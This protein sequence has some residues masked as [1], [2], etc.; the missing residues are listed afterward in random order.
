M[1]DTRRLIPS[2]SLRLD[3]RGFLRGFTAG[4]AGMALGS[5]HV[6]GET[7]AAPVAVPDATVN[8]VAGT[9]RRDMVYQAL[10][11]FAKEVKEGIKGKQVIVKPNM[12]VVNVPLCATHADALRGVLDFLKPLTKQTVL[13]AE[14]TLSKEGSF[15]GFENYGYMPLEK[16]YNARLV[17]LNKQPP[18]MFW[19]LDKNHHPLGIR[20]IS[21]FLDPKNYFISVSR[22]KT[23]DTVVATLTGK[24]MFMSAPLNDYTKSDKSLMHQGIKEINWNLFQVAGSVHPQLAVLDGL[25][26]MQGNGPISGVAAPH[27]VALAGTDYVAVDH[28]GA[29]LMGVDFNDIGYLTYCAS[30][31]YGQ[32][33]R[34]K[35]QVTGEDPARHVMKYRMHEK[36]EEELTWKS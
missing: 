17:D 5:F 25:E 35:I 11:P 7:P 21:T 29:E 30:A 6:Y 27:G 13:I 4:A 9:D 22:L 10:K 24:N 26:G 28:I 3:R 33:D 23:H 15:K 8:L 18:H 1:H 20:L 19:I 31:G 34:A 36:I 2:T 32:G 16:E 12:V 14:S